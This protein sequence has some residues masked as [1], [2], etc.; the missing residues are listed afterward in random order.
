MN[1]APWDSLHIFYNS[2][3]YRLLTDCIS[4]LV[5]TLTERGDL[6]SY[7]FI[8]YWENGPHVRL[9]FR[10]T[11][12]RLRDA[13]TSEITNALQGFLRQ[14]PSMFK[15]PSKFMHPAFQKQFIAEYSEE[16]LYQKYGPEGHIP[17]RPNNSVAAI[18]YYPEH[19]RYGGPAGVAVAERYFQKSSDFV[20]EQLS[21]PNGSDFG[22]LLG[23]AFRFFLY[24]CQVFLNPEEVPAF[25][26]SYYRAWLGAANVDKKDFEAGIARKFDRQRQSLHGALTH[27]T[28]VTQDPNGESI[29]HRWVRELASIKRD[30]DALDLSL[31]EPA[32]S[33]TISQ[34]GRYHYLLP[35]YIHMHNNRLGLAVSD[36]PYVA[37]LALRLFQEQERAA[38]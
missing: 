15:V 17:Y 29:D 24:W 21:G 16:E 26:Q 19:H 9:R 12:E 13:V 20:L 8:R 35:S 4:P 1:N 31:T 36:E 6:D 27:C 37:Y 34:V 2:D 7:F 38:A 5:K 18:Q 33:D 23:H 11:S 10:P 22:V 30:V 3:P 32:I 25:C 28:H 14:R